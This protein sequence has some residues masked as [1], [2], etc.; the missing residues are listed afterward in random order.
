M[1]AVAADRATG[2]G[3]HVL[4]GGV[5]LLYASFDGTSISRPVEFRAAD[6]TLRERVESPRP[7]VLSQAASDRV[8]AQDLWRMSDHVMLDGGLR[9]DASSLA[10]TMLSPRA[11][12]I[13]SVGPAGRGILRG[14]AGLFVERM[15]LMAGAFEA[16]VA[17]RAHGVHTMRTARQ[18]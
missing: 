4:K 7:A 12:A 14:G 8:Y 3:D 1:G 13:V 6:G 18:P 10:G 9:L 2:A 17:A 15:P 11:G 16:F 5:D